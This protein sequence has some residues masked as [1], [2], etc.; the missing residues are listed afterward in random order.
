MTCGHA[1]SFPSTC[2][3]DADKPSPWGYPFPVRDAWVCYDYENSSCL[4]LHEQALAEPPTSVLNMTEETCL[5]MQ[6]CESHS[7]LVGIPAWNCDLFNPRCAGFGLVGLPTGFSQEDET[8]EF[9]CAKKANSAIAE[10]FLWRWPLQSSSDLAWFC[11]LD[12]VCCCV[13]LWICFLLGK[14]GGR[15]PKPPRRLKKQ[16]S[17]AP[18]QSGAKGLGDIRWARRLVVICWECRKIGLVRAKRPRLW[19]RARAWRL[20]NLSQQ[21]GLRRRG[22]TEATI[23]RWLRRRRTQPQTKAALLPAWV[24][25]GQYNWLLGTRI[26][27][28]SNPGPA[29]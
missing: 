17:V 1:S 16:R 26:G 18:R 28:A 19:A 21:T 29:T 22:A 11:L 2:I 23:T 20:R 15:S 4:Q 12:A 27:E 3:L 5:G 14:T 9:T 25:P 24:G 13:A 6:A 10:L 7:S 8:P